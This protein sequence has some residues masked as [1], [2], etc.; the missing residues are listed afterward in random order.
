MSDSDPDS[1]AAAM[2]AAMGFST[3]GAAPAKKKRKFNANTDAFVA[4]QELEN[5]DRGGKKG[6]GS[7]GN[8]VAL[9]KVRTFGTGAVSESPVVV[10]RP[11]E[12]DAEIELELEVDGDGD[13]DG[14][15]EERPNYIDTSLP[16]PMQEMGSEEQ[17]DAQ[18][19]I[20]EILAR[21]S[22]VTDPAITDSSSLPSVPGYAPLPSRPPPQLD[23]D[24]AVFGGSMGSVAS[25]SAGGR[26]SFPRKGQYNERWWDGYYDPAFNTNPWA[27]LELKMGLEPVGQWL[28]DGHWQRGGQRA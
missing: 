2:A 25:S 22:G 4:G 8:N 5:I 19:K 13:G 24:T 10:S 15:G 27:T 18:W 28:Q 9:G 23:S 1:E 11:V 17:E 6:K 21:S 12:N 26:N 14:E 3:F 16:A 20:D 7:G